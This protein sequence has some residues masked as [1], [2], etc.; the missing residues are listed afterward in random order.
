MYNVLGCRRAVPNGQEGKQLGGPQHYGMSAAP[1]FGVPRE[2]VCGRLA[3]SRTGMG[4]V[5]ADV[6]GE[7]LVRCTRRAA[8]VGG[9]ALQ[10]RRAP[11]GRPLS[12]GR[13]C[14]FAAAP[15]FSF[16]CHRFL[17]RAGRNAQTHPGSS[18]SSVAARRPH[19]PPIWIKTACSSVER[20]ERA[21]DA[22]GVPEDRGFPA[23]SNRA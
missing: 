12:T 4:S 1:K 17:P 14:P 18:L 15:L 8:G 5:K 9:V 2:A 11:I 21:P 13:D 22:V 23:V 6:V 16:N 10:D 19:Q 7:E 20:D 3:E